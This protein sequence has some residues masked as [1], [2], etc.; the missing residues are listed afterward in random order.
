LTQFAGVIFA[1][2]SCVDNFVKLYGALP[3]GKELITMGRVTE[4]KLK[5]Y[6]LAKIITSK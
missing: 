4:N 1:S 6:E 2:P 5:E 3:V